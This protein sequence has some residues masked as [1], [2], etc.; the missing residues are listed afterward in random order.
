MLH[1]RDGQSVVEYIVVLA[2]FITLVG[3]ALWEIFSTLKVKFDDV[4][5]EIG[6]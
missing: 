6:S 3:G 4:N 5:A 1:D 2:I